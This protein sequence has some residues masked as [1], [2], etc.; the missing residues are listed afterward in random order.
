MT[1]PPIVQSEVLHTAVW[2][3]QYPLPS[4]AVAA[5]LLAPLLMSRRA[6][7][8][9]RK[10]VYASAAAAFLLHVMP[11]AFAEPLG[12][13]QMFLPAPA[14]TSSMLPVLVS[15]DAIRMGIRLLRRRLLVPTPRRAS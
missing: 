8:V 11:A 5:A 1:P 12:A 2:L 9:I 4:T 14:V 10:V 7:R 3:I 15:G 13:L 6:R